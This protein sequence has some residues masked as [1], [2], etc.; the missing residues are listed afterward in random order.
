M[1]SL[2]GSEESTPPT[3]K[4]RIGSP[5]YSNSSA[6]TQNASG[7]F[8]GLCHITLFS[9]LL[10]LLINIAFGH[11]FLD[12]MD[13]MDWG[14]FWRASLTLIVKPIISMH[15]ILGIPRNVHAEFNV[16]HFGG[17]IL[18]WLH[19]TGQ[20]VRCSNFKTSAYT[21]SYKGTAV[22]CSHQNMV[23]CKNHLVDLNNIY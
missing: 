4:P 17:N 2:S 10:F 7:I 5:T 3:K 18:T 8:V 11:S 14:L 9:L 23:R 20:N 12:C 1:S 22:Y 13:H 19:V 6:S 15:H 21:T 16:F